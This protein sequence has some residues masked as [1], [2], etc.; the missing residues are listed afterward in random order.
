VKSLCRVILAG[1]L[2]WPTLG[3]WAQAPES[4]D[5]AEVSWAEMYRFFDEPVDPAIYLVRPGERLTVTF[6]GAKI[7]PL[8]LTVDPQGQIV[9]QTLGVFDLSR[10]TLGE[11]RDILEATLADHYR[12]DQIEISVSE[13]R[14]VAVQVSGAVA[15]PGTYKGFTSHRASEVI[16]EAGGVQAHGST[17]RIEFSGGP[18]TLIVDLDR[19][20]YLGDNSSNPCLY[21]GYSLHVPSKSSERVQVVGEVNH[22]REIELSDGD[23]VPTLIALAGGPRANADLAHVS[24]SRGADVIHNSEPGAF[25][26][27]QPG[28]VIT[29][30]PTER[31]EDQAML[32]LFGAVTTPG[33]YLYRGNVTTASLIEQAGGFTDEASRGMV[34]LFRK[35]G[36]DEWGRVSETRY[37]ITS[38]VGADDGVLSMR[39]LPGDSVYVPFRVGFVKV[40]GEVLNPG[41]YPFIDG[42][43]ALFYIKTAGGFLP[44]ADRNG[45]SVYNRV[46]RTTAEFST[47]VLVHDGDELIVNIKEELQ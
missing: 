38:A 11:V 6:V 45:I 23:D 47:G 18:E 36:A 41:R 13:P 22:P 34:T 26:D 31:T 8:T 32:R 24:V 39:L 15:H 4:S 44:K 9:D 29:V 10:R 30:P 16:E 3:V 35:A 19:V 17:R 21:A 7:G 2:L 42:K 33:M 27:L 12:A 25:P 46:A 5:S 37:P 28:D 20:D 43:D 1:L 40:S 14:R